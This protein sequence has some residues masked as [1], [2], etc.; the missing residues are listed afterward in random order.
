MKFGPVPVEEAEGKILG[1][2]ITRPDGR[3]LFR[4]GRPLSAADVSELQSLGRAVIYVAELETGDSTE[5][6]AARRIARSVSG[7]GLR[8][9]G[10][11]AGR[12]N[13]LGETLG[14]LRVDIPR[15]ISLNRS[16]GV[17]LATLAASTVVQPRQMVATVKI[18]PYAIPERVVISIEEGAAVSGPLIRLG[19]APPPAGKP[20]SLRFTGIP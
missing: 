10:A 20:D 7:P 18:I 3:R 4:K 1:H 5:D 8:L 19:G 14:V 6:E 17:T 13:I 16:E 2:N 15:L 11:T 12:V 9:K